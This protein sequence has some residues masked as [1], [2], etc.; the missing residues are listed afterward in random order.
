MFC[1]SI[2]NAHSTWNGLVNKSCNYE[3]EIERKHCAR[4]FAACFN[5]SQTRWRHVSTQKTTYNLILIVRFF[6]FEKNEEKKKISLMKFDFLSLKHMFLFQWKQ[7]LNRIDIRSQKRYTFDPI[8]GQKPIIL[9]PHF[10]T[11]SWIV[12]SFVLIF[13]LLLFI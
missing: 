2:E 5:W 7:Q 6:S 13:L 1:R 4:L 3:Y 12:C 10:Q 8:Y 11:I 9:F